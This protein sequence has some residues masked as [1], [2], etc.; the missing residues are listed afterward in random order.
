MK[1]I[2]LIIIAIIATLIAV[3]AAEAYTYKVK[4]PADT[5]DDDTPTHI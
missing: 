3:V 1:Y 5:H 2:Y 4:P